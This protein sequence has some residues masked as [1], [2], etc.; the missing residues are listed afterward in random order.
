MSG[1]TAT[2]PPGRPSDDVLATIDDATARML[3]TVD[4]LE[5]TD[6]SAG[7]VLPDW[8]RAHVVAHLALNA[9]GMAGVLEGLRDGEA[10]S[11]YVSD[12]RRDGDI[13]ELAAADP[14]TIR[15][16]LHDGAAR[17]AGVVRRVPAEAWS[18]T[19][20]RLPGVSPMPAGVIPGM[21]LREVE[22]HHADLGAGF[23]HRAWPAGF[24]ADLLDTMA[25]DHAA[26]G[27][28]RVTATDLGRTWQVGD[29]NG[30][31]DGPEVTGTGADLGWWLVGRERSPELRC[32]ADDL[33]EIGPWRRSPLRRD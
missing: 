6:W 5:D 32:D 27:P 15:E 3:R 11:M 24:V 30:A 16:R 2:T 28:F 4:S 14:A 8:T 21:R 12:V 13:D 10:T 29:A 26:S 25:V 20:D 22:I 31:E 7:T 23:S 1:M 33:P 17:F 9:E 19:F 18:G